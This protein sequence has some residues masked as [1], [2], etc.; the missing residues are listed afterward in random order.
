[1]VEQWLLAAIEVVPELDDPDL[2]E[3]VDRLKS[4]PSLAVRAKAEEVLSART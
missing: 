4:D 1:M 2:W 3:R